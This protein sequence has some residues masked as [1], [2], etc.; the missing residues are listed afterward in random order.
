MKKRIFSIILAVIMLISSL[1][2][3]TY[4]AATASGSCGSD[5]NWELSSK[6]KLTLTGSGKMYDYGYTSDT[7]SP[8]ND[9]RNDIKE[10]K[11]SDGITVLG[12]YAFYKFS[13]LTKISIPDSVTE[14]RKD[15]FKGCT[16]LKSYT[17]PDKVTEISRHLFHDCT[18]L[19][20]IT[21]HKGVKTIHTNA[22]ENCAAFTDIVYEG[23]EA[24][25]K[26][27]NFV[28]S[29]TEELKMMGVENF[30]IKDGGL[31]H[32]CVFSNYETDVSAGKKIAK[33]ETVYCFKTKSKKSYGACGDKHFFMYYLF[34]NDDSY[35]KN[36]TET[37]L[38]YV[39]CGASHTRERENSMLIDS[40]S[41]FKDVKKGA[42][43]VEYIDF[44]VGRAM[45]KGTSE[46]TFEPNSN[47]T[48]AM[49]VTILSRLSGEELS[50]K[51]NSGFK[52]VPTDQW[53]TGAV[54]WAYEKGIT[55]GTGDG[56]SPDKNITRQE[57]CAM[58]V[59]FS[60]RQGI[61]LD[62]GI[63]TPLPFSFM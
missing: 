11:I 18:S 35:Y 26:E 5:I 52:D 51:V 29:S 42:W 21:I 63:P 8:W 61:L 10:V 50:N 24:Q 1:S 12:E 19:E 62:S 34:N 9:Y 23:S 28:Y 14:I 20:K 40:V 30:K 38:C 39:D 2:V 37:S 15:V 13:N 58:L 47:I 48:R 54:K 46:T 49:F 33:C 55:N 45:F 27:I 41:E 31:K 3:I 56:F 59:R 57:L 53:Y 43:Y 16:S 7:Y 25:W 36:G 60:D 17:V 32:D 44:A 6:G 22:F 4:A